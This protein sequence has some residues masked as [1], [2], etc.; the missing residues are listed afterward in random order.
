MTIA[1]GFSDKSRKGTSEGTKSN[2]LP[3]SEFSIFL[4]LKYFRLGCSFFIS[5]N[6]LV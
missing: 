6:K 1:L 2:T 4:P 5:Y 3:L